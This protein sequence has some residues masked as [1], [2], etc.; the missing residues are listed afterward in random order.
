MHLIRWEDNKEATNKQT[1]NMVFINSFGT[2]RWHMP[3]GSTIRPERYHRW[4]VEKYRLSFRLKSIELM[5]YKLTERT[6][7]RFFVYSSIFMRFVLRDHVGS[8]EFGKTSNL[9]L[10]DIR[11]QQRDV[12]MYR[13]SW[14]HSN[15]LMLSSA[16][17][18][19]KRC[20]MHRL[21]YSP[22]NRCRGNIV[23]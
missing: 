10:H 16:R 21:Y 14:S 6:G 4:C 8:A 7:I 15:T 5:R 23:S 3:F 1:K 11:Q 22:K 2:Y 19:A 12:Y 17:T 18:S 20:R 13:V 9:P